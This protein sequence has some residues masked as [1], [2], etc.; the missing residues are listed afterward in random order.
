MYFFT[1]DTHFGH[2]NIIKYCNRPFESV[3]DMDKQLIANWNSVVGKNDTVFHLGDFAFYP[4]D[5]TL[6]ILSRLNG[7]INIVPGNHDK[8]LVKAL[9]SPENYLGLR[10]NLLD[11]IHLQTFVVEDEKIPFVLCHYAMKAW[12]KA[13]YGAVHLYGHSHGTLADDPHSRSMD[14]GV[15]T[16]KYSPY[17]IDDI[18]LHMYKKIHNA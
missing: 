5:I 2:K 17:S 8:N 7:Y 11:S 6:G 4:Q 9:N 16:N 15:D 3:H 13:H 18:L 12:D 14:V 1:S 10:V